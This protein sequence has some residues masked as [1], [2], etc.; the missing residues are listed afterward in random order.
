MAKSKIVITFN[1]NPSI[2]QQLVIRNSLSEIDILETFKTSR[3]S[4]YQSEL[5]EFVPNDGI[6]PD[7]YLGYASQFYSN[8]LGLDYNNTNLY[9]ITVVNGVVNS[10]IGSVTIEAT[11]SNVV[12]SEITNTTGGAVTTTIFNE[13]EIA[14]ITIDSITFSTA[15]TDLCNN[16]NVNV[17]TSITA[18]KAMLNNITLNNPSNP[19]NYDFIR[20]INIVLSVSDANGNKA[21][22]TI[23]LPK[24]LVVVNTLISIINSPSGATVTTTVAQADGL[25]LQ[26]SLNNT[27]WKSENF[28]AG[29]APGDYT[30]YIKD[31]L[32]CAIQKDFTISNFEDSGTGVGVNIPHAKLP[33]KANSIRFKKLVNWG[34]CGNY[35]NDEN[36]LSYEVDV[37]FPDTEIQKFQSCDTN[38]PTQIESNYSNIEVKVVKCDLTEDIIPVVKKTNFIGLKDK[39]DAIKYDLGDGLTG[40]YFSSGNI[41]NY[42]TSLL[43]D[44]YALNGAVPEWSYKDNY[45]VIDNVWYL[46]ED[47]IFDETKLAEVIV[48]KNVFTGSDETIIVGSVYNLFNH[49]D[50]EFYIDMSVY[51]D[52]LIQV[53][54]IETDTR[55]ETVTFISEAISVKIKQEN[56]M[57]IIYFNETNTDI[58]YGTRIIHKIRIPYITKNGKSEDD[59][60]IQDTDT[61][62]ILISASLREGDEFIFEPQT[63]EMWRKLMIALSHTNVT[64][65]GIPRIKN[66]AF[67]T[68]GP[69]GDTDSYVLTAIMKKVDGTFNSQI[70]DSSIYT[71]GSEIEIPGV[72]SS[73][74]DYVG[75]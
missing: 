75:Y 4:N 8:A 56:T 23:V 25:V 62:S 31:Q 9:N 58:N 63:K 47:V 59:S 12:F 3:E 55:F 17:T 2:N 46:I 10:G 52:K 35:K 27:T 18:V 70:S 61:N 15:D 30:I 21:Y 72:I 73:G 40:I 29:L 64:M 69:L 34:I 33:S 37:P 32:G 41:Y 44:T 51:E 43:E 54:I 36:T 7:R 66:G 49:E 65:D 39:R 20:G 67:N 74:G 22:Q 11:Q 28:Y 50:Y 26:Y 19:F 1:S 53:H 71:D 6:H 24:K 42:D 5:P 13:T 48:I 68:E 57:E 14:P 16:V 45:I 38:I 60:E